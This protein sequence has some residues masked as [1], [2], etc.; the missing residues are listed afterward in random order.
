MG[1][2]TEFIS[3]SNF[4][5]GKDP[6]FR[7]SWVVREGQRFL[8]CPQGHDCLKL[9]TVHMPQCHPL[10]GHLP[11]AATQTHWC[12]YKA[13]LCFL[14]RAVIKVTAIP[15]C[16]RRPQGELSPTQVLAQGQKRQLLPRLPA[17]PPERPWRAAGCR[18]L[19][20]CQGLRGLLSHTLFLEV[21]LTEH[22][23]GELWSQ[24]HGMPPKPVGCPA[25]PSG[26]GCRGCSSFQGDSSTA[27]GRSPLQV[28]RPQR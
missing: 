22:G 19:H 2:Q 21:S 27:A 9:R 8:L 5:F 14:A 26:N 16:L 1:Y 10:K 13:W 11:L 7:F 17:E 6:K 24:T 4:Y 23:A 28:L 25:G 15:S 3:V 12:H 20:G 18:D